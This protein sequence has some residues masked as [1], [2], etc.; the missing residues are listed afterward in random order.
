MTVNQQANTGQLGQDATLASLL[1][2]IPKDTTGTSDTTT[3]TP[4]NSGFALLGSLL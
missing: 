3:T 1:G 4:N 2:A